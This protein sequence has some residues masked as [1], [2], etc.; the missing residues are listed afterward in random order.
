MTEPPT[1]LASAPVDGAVQSADDADD[2]GITELV[3][4]W[5]QRPAN[6]AIVLVATA[7]IAGMIGWLI[8]ESGHNVASS[9]VDVGFLQDMSDHHRQAVD[10]SFSFL[11]RP[12]TDPQ[13]QTVAR[14]IIFE[15]SVEIGVM[16]QLL[17]GMD[18][19][20]SA[21]DGQS[22]AWMGHA[23][24]AAEMPG[25]AA[26]EDL[27]RLAGAQGRAA[28]ELFVELMSA[29]HRGG[30]EM[31]TAAAARAENA[32]VERF[33]ASWARNQQSEITELEGLLTDP[34]GA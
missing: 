20:S 19:P 30:I 29:H 21:E 33:A 26:P 28:D 7:L 16:L 12:E 14:G 22:M 31:A 32:D 10:M 15:Q 34:A 18:A 3:L 27:D 11:S 17:A 1:D 4:P 8:A 24:D 13:L 23:M 25:M 6:I 5:W 9:D 2:E